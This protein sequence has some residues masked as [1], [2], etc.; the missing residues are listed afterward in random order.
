MNR[1]GAWFAATVLLFLNLISGV[2]AA[3]SPGCGK[4]P[5][6]KDGR[7]NVTI[8]GKAREYIVKLPANYDKS[9]PYRLIFTFHPLSGSA[10]QVTTGLMGVG[11]Y[12]GL[13][14]LA[15]ESAIFVSPNGLMEEIFNTTLRGWANVG[16]EDIK[17]VDAMIETVEADLC[18]DQKLRFST[19]FSYGGAISYALGCARASQFRAIGILSGGSMSGCQGNNPVSP[20]ATYQQHGTTD[21]VG[22]PSLSE[23]CRIGT[24]NLRLRKLTTG[25]RV[26]S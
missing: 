10:Q 7:Y 26:G 23:T 12:Y 19:G 13:P 5:T 21:S 18:V 8:N 1:H 16:G 6:I 2:V 22:I 15:N 25:C 17:F 9:R 11:P 3:N 14:S 4:S 24:Y 20:I